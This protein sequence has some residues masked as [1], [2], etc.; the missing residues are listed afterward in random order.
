MLCHAR[1]SMVAA[2]SGRY[3]EPIGDEQTGLTDLKAFEEPTARQSYGRPPWADTIPLRDEPEIGKR[4][5]APARTAVHRKPKRRRLPSSWPLWCVLAVQAGLSARLIWSNTA[6]T[7]EA[8]YL[9]AG[10]LEWAHW[11][12]G[13]SIRAEAFPTYF[14]GALAVYP[15][16]GAL[17]DSLGGLAGARLL[18]L[19]F[20]L[21]A[22]VLLHGV[23][24]RIFDRTAALF[25][26]ALFAG[27]PATQFLGAFA[28]YDAL[29]LMLL[30]L[31]T[32]LGVW[33]AGRRP[34]AQAALLALAGVVLALAN[35]AKY[36]S[37]LF[38]PAAVAVAA[39][40][41]LRVQGR[42]ASLRG[43]AT[44]LLALGAL[45]AAGLWLGGA[46][47]WQGITFTTLSRS[48]GTY[49]ASG[50]LYV[51]AGWLVFTLPL[52]VLGAILVITRRRRPGD[53][54][55][56][57]AL[58]LAV[59]LAPAEQ[60]RI[61][62]FTSL[63]KHVGYGAWFGCAIAGCALASLASAVPPAKARKAMAASGAVAA[64]A[65][66]PGA[67]L[68]SAHFQGWPDLT[69]VIA[70]LRPLLAD[71]HG[72]ILASDSGH[73]IQYYLP[74]RRR[75]TRSPR[76][77]G[78]PTG[79]LPPGG[80]S[81]GRQPIP[82]PSGTGRSRRSPSPTIR[83]TTAFATTRRCSRRSRSTGATGWWPACRTLPGPCTPPSPCGSAKRPAGE[84]A[85]QG[86]GPGRAAR[87]RNHHAIRPDS[88]GEG[89]LRV[90]FAALPGIGDHPERAVPRLSPR[91][92]WRS[93]TR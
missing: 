8:L 30:A 59:V 46:A 32:W 67:R 65:V 55:L 37:A 27:L 36:A 10:H 5:A 56:A 39:L 57:L 6:F 72:S 87:K 45:L 71:V 47:Y 85:E 17:A 64:A 58:A 69:L 68:A 12:H 20:M 41:V 35:A 89:V 79:I 61:H 43:L 80:P 83:M 62:T 7:D 2:V 50:I 25:A 93:V 78:I 54:L 16:L 52:A 4:G 73:T 44:M 1:M 31:A 75:M 76:L 81:A 51:G 22:T 91:R 90:A 74:A 3:M 34:G 82:T 88:R 11:L 23:T 92:G 9:W 60:A 66:L 18:S 15:P 70:E 24:R 77:G 13:T 28:T 33:A 19:A 14:S 21:A 26:A 49:P 86:G 84:R 48:V 40:A 53:R 42:G 29:A 63:F 38:D